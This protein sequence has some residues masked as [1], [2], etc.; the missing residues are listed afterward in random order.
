MAEMR[1]QIQEEKYAKVIPI[2][3]VIWTKHWE[4]LGIILIE[5][6][7][8]NNATLNND[9]KSIMRYALTQPVIGK[10]IR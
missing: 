4:E 1:R 9:E 5:E 8:Y 7:T 2:A 10:I 3:Q 6:E